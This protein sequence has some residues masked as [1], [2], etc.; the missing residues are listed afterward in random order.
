M[1]RTLE[2]YCI[3]GTCLE[4]ILLRVKGNQKIIFGKTKLQF[5]TKKVFFLAFLEVGHRTLDTGHG[6]TGRWDIGHG[7]T[8]SPR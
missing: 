8:G 2:K 1:T 5:D 7:A 3:W 4:K 6:A